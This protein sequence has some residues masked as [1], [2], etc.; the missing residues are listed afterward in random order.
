[1][2]NNSQSKMCS[3]NN[4]HLVGGRSPFSKPYRN[5]IRELCRLHDYITRVV[6]GLE[7]LTDR[8]SDQYSAPSK[9]RFEFEPVL[10]MFPYMK[11][12]D[13]SQLELHR[14]LKGTAYL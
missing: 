10:T 2:V 3:L 5:E 4:T 8:F 7:F 1:M 14:R 11:T 12:R 13:I 6:A 9:A